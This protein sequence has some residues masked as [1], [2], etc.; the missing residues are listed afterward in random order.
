MKRFEGLRGKSSKRGL[1]GLAAIGGGTFMV[2]Y[3]WIALAGFHAIGPD[4]TFAGEGEIV[5]GTISRPDY[6]AFLGFIENQSIFPCSITPPNTHRACSRP[7]EEFVA[8]QG[9][10]CD[11]DGAGGCYLLDPPLPDFLGW[12]QGEPERCAMIDY[13]GIADRWLQ[14]TSGGTISMG[15]AFQGSVTERALEDGRAEVR[16]ILRTTNALTWVI[17]GCDRRNGPVLFGH[18]PQEILGGLDPA[19]GAAE[20]NVTYVDLVPGTPIPDL[21][22]I[23]AFPYHGQNVYSKSMRATADGPL[24]S[25][26]GVLEGTAGK[27]VVTYSNIRFAS[28]QG[29]LAGGVPV[30]RIDLHVLER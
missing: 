17:E 7:I 16:V 13:A 15:T 29:A 2:A 30:D 5:D 20:L 19:L 12:W 11:S 8:A 24:R 22:Q 3:I 21:I 28:F 27:A 10:W 23:G 14:E 26:F 4:V 18:R 9:T 1:L 6:E 25:A